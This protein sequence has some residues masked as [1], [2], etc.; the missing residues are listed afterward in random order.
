MVC[1][2][3]YFLSKFIIIGDDCAGI[4]VGTQIFSG[5][6]TERASYTKRSDQLLFI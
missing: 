3:S 1:K 5:I 6:K 2:H 4:A